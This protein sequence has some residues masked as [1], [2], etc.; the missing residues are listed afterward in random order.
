MDVALSW[1]INGSAVV[2]H[3]GESGYPFIEGGF[4]S[5]V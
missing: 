5:I 4:G 3:H 2:G 1:R